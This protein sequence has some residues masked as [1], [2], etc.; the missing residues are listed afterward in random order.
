MSEEK[1]MKKADHMQLIASY[2]GKYTVIAAYHKFFDK[3]N[4]TQ[5]ANLSDLM[6]EVCET[7]EDGQKKA[8]LLLR[9]LAED[10]V[11]LSNSEK[12]TYSYIKEKLIFKKVEK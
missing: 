11:N 1:L 7:E 9:D 12:I 10:I 2:L 6:K 4:S 3:Y 5:L 8:C